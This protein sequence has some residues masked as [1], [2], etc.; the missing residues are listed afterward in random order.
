[1]CMFVSFARGNF[2]SRALWEATSQ[3]CIVEREQKWTNKIWS[4]RF[5]EETEIDEQKKEQ[6]FSSLKEMMFMYLVFIKMS[7]KEGKSLLKGI[8]GQV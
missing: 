4:L 7:S 6:I 3:K 2:Q 1:M 5:R 8:K